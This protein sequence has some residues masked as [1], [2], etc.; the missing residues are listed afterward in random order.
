VVPGAIGTS[1]GPGGVVTTHPAPAMAFRRA[2]A[3]TVL[4]PQARWIAPLH[5][6]ALGVS[7]MTDTARLTIIQ[8]T[9]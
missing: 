5:A 6:R 1:P 8:Y 2:A 4:R 3:S 9:I 7:R